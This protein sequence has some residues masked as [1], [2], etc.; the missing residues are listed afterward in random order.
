MILIS[1]TGNVYK[2]VNSAGNELKTKN[3][4]FDIKFLGKL[5]KSV[6]SGAIKMVIYDITG[7]VVENYAG[8]FKYFPARQVSCTPTNRCEP[9]YPKDDYNDNYNISSGSTKDNCYMYGTW[10]KPVL[11]VHDNLTT[12]STPLEKRLK[13]SLILELNNTK[14]LIGYRAPNSTES[15][16]FSFNKILE[17]VSPGIAATNSQISPENIIF[18]DEFLMGLIG[19][20]HSQFKTIY[21]SSE[22]G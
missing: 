9:E 11:W 12:D 19:Q 5:H 16:K 17:F 18:T 6:E 3:Y 21:L 8:Q 10:V 7:L 2:I 13:Y 15:A 14:E 22:G 20:R 4:K 1:N